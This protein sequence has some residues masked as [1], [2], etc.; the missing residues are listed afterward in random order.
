MEIIDYSKLRYE[1]IETA[2]SSDKSRNKAIQNA[3]RVLDG[4]DYSVITENFVKKKLYFALVGKEEY[5]KCF[6]TSEYM[7]QIFNGGGGFEYTTIVCG[8]LKSI[9]QLAKKLL[10]TT[11]I[12]FPEKELWIKK[13]NNRCKIERYQ[14]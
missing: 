13:N 1:I 4:A 2:H 6:V 12:N 10:D 8:Y 9:E 11:L 5:A 7:F 14:A 3:N